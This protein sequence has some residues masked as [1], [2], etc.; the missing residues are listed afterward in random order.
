MH[1]CS[2]NKV[3]YFTVHT[4]PPGASRWYPSHN[5]TPAASLIIL[6]DVVY[7]V[8]VDIT[9]VRFIVLNF[10]KGFLVPRTGMSVMRRMEKHSVRLKFSRRFT[11]CM[12]MN[13]HSLM[14]VSQFQLT[15]MFV[16]SHTTMWTC[17][18]KMMKGAKS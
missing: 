17:L 9:A 13:S 15:C 3:S 5:S 6:L 4:R 7:Q 12:K 14:C 8:Y 16:E 11:S 2:N 18:G 1:Y 10:L